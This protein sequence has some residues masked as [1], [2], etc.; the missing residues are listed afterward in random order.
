MLQRLPLLPQSNLIHNDRSFND[1]NEHTVCSLMHFFFQEAAQNGKPVEFLSGMF[2][3]YDSTE[4]FFTQ[5]MIAKN[6]QLH[7][8]EHRSGYF[9]RPAY[10]FIDL[11]KSLFNFLRQRKTSFYRP[12]IY[13]RGD[14]SSHFHERGNKHDRWH[15]YPAYGIDMAHGCM[16]NGFSHIL[17]GKLRSLA[18]NTSRQYS[19]DRIYIKPEASGLQQFPQYLAHANHYIRAV[20]Y[21]FLCRFIDNF[22][23][24]FCTPT[25]AFHEWVDRRLAKRWTQILATIKSLAQNERRQMQDQV[26]SEGILQIYR[27]SLLFPPLPYVKDFRIELEHRYGSDISARKANEI[28]FTTEQL[29]NSSPSCTADFSM[30]DKQQCVEPDV[31]IQ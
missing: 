10:F 27:Q 9:R 12:F 1:V 7:S 22:T 3:L 15:L 30:N 21:S 11:L 4:R 5:L 28:I 29:L 25:G 8:D 13:L 2:I 19:G 24:Q 23:P 18:N 17:F 16:P 6:N 20:S 31:I 26:F 14:E